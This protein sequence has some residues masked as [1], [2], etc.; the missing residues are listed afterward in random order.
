[1]AGY[2]AANQWRI[3][4]PITKKVRIS[5]D[6][7]S[8]LNEHDEKVGEFWSP[9]DDEQL[10]LQ[11]KKLDNVISKQTKEVVGDVVDG[12]ATE[13]NVREEERLI[14]NSDNESFLSPLE[15][16]EPL[17]PSTPRSPPMTGLFPLED[18]S[19]QAPTPRPQAPKPRGRASAPLPSDRET[20]SMTGSSKPCFRYMNC[21]APSQH[22]M[23][24]VLNALQSGDYLGLSKAQEPQNY[25]AAFASPESTHWIKAI[26]SKYD[27][28]IHENETWDL[29]ELPSDRKVLT[30]RWVF[31]IKY[32]LNGEIRKYK[33]RWVVHGHKQKYGVDY[34]KMWAGVV[35]PDSFRSLFLIG[36]SRNLHIKQMDV[37]TAFLYGLLDE[38]VYV[39][40]PHRFVQGSL[41]CRL[42]RA[43]YG[44]KQAPRVWYLVIRNFLKEKGLIATD[45]D[46]RVFI[47]ADKQ[48]FLAIY[49][50]DLFLFGVNKAQIDVL[51]RELCS[52][53]QMTDLGEVSHYLGMETRRDREKGT[54]MLLQ[55]AYLKAV[56]ERFGMSDCNPSSTPMDNGLPNT[57]MP[58][59]SR[60]NSLVCI[61]CWVIDVC[62]D[63]DST[64]HCIC[65]INCKSLL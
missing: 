32:S 50:D 13:K 65:I 26:Q 17:I 7:R 54:L 20:Q 29:T 38:I 41:V 63:N 59:P 23:H 19:D 16:E 33:A 37:V 58:G 39:K 31:K 15:E 53:F 34:N 42:K 27:S 56:L 46:Q 11:E 5:R 22:Y 10:A 24:K 49:V 55:T 47:S 35:K 8:R 9:E 2:E 51:K 25:K 60:H 57:V 44:L 61:S 12:T 48:L 45:S 14:T 1:M 18:D 52:C 6:V 64:R 21:I 3:Y 30:G 62:Y 28:L 40:Q 4:N 43:L 36:A